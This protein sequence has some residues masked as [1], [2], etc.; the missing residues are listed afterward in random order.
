MKSCNYT[1]EYC[2][3]AKAAASEKMVARDREYLQ[4]FIEF[5][6]GCNQKCNLFFAPR[7]EALL[8]D[9]YQKALLTLTKFENTGEIVIQTNLSGSLEWLA[10]ADSSKLILWT[11]YHPSQVESKRF[12]DQVKKLVSY[13]VR[14]TVGTVGVKENFPE[15]KE[16]DHLLTQLGKQKPYLWINAYKDK[17][18]YYSEEETQYLSQWDRLFLSNLKDYKC[19][20][21]ACRT[22]EDVFFIEWNGN[23]HRCWQDKRI[24]GNL[25]TDDL[26]AMDAQGNCKKKICGCFIGY[27][28]IKSLKL[29]QVY[30]SSLLGRI[31]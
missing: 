12:F 25:Y 29:D 3:F 27:S 23:I 5:I 20:D 2:P 8:Y 6:A 1:C 4:K 16:I 31:P 21:I 18:N 28:N 19:R 11:T 30:K 24:I 22:G 17:R 9:Y 10:N 14:F 13:N 26:R 15:I 7:G